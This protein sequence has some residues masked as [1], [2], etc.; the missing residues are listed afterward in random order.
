MVGVGLKDT[1]ARQGCRSSTP[2]DRGGGAFLHAQSHHPRFRLEPGDLR[3]DVIL[4]ARLVVEAY[5]ELDASRIGDVQ[6]RRA[7]MALRIAVNAERLQGRGGGGH[8][9]G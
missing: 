4:A 3:G 6:K 9:E 2:H 1:G 7:L 8:H 5:P